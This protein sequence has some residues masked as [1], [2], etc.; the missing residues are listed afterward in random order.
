MY[1]QEVAQGMMC[2]FWR[3]HQAQ[4][5]RLFALGIDSAMKHP[6]QVCRIPRL[7][8]IEQRM[9]SYLSGCCGELVSGE[10]DEIA[11]LQFF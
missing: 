9:R 11:L 6:Q 7:K 2:A 3:P 4:Q 8:G 1:E 5:P 10:M